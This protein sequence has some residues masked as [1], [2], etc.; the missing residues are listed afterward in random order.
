MISGLARLYAWPRNILLDGEDSG[1]LAQPGAIRTTP[2]CTTTRRSSNRSTSSA[3]LTW[4]SPSRSRRIQRKR[5]RSSGPPRGGRRH[6]RRDRQGD[7]PGR[8]V[9]RSAYSPWSARTSVYNSFS[10]ISVIINAL[11]TE[12]AL[13]KQVESDEE[14]E[15]ERKAPGANGTLL[16]R[17]RIPH[18]TNPLHSP[19]IL[20]PDRSLLGGTTGKITVIS[21]RRETAIRLSRQHRSGGTPLGRPTGTTGTT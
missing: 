1:V 13:R 8:P 9:C 20:A 6:R 2:S 4:S 5:S 17:V 18:E 3:A 10:A 16:C 19:G 21:G 14:P 7:I 15:G 12:V 11:T